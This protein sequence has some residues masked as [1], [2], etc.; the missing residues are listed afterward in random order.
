MTTPR[1][2]AEQLRQEAI[3]TLLTERDAIDAQLTLL[4]HEKT[5]PH[6]KRGR[7]PKQ[8]TAET[9]HSDNFQGASISPQSTPDAKM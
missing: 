7:P 1:E 8:R 3:R 6:K 9:D 4:G 5:A 2:H